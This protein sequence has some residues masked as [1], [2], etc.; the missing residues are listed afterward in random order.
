MEFN[1][2]NDSV[3][4]R[5][6]LCLEEFH[7]IR[8][9]I[10]GMGSMSHPIPYLTRYSIMRACGAIEYGF[11]T[12]IADLNSEGQSDQIKTFIDNK[13]RNSSLNP[14]YSNICKS[15]LD[16]D[17]KWSDKFKSEINNQEHKAR[18]LDSLSSL[19]D[20]RNAFAHG[21]SPS[22]S[23]SNVEI[24]FRDSVKVLESIEKAVASN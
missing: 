23:F 11:K 6:E 3:A 5:I 10:D 7:K 24:Y 22:T 18:I 19:N 4:E 20:A 12:I 9:I 1:I 16:F 15:L 8:C 21:G 17:S 13:F 14:N 2:N